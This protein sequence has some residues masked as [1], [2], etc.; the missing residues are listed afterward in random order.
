MAV[1]ET[2]TYRVCVKARLQVAASYP[3]RVDLPRVLRGERY[4][5]KSPTAFTEGA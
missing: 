2:R 4:S 5:A 1:S 3:H